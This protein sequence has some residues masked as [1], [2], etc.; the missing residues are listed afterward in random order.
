MGWDIRILP[1]FPSRAIV[2]TAS[3]TF[4][5]RAVLL[6]NDA[7]DTRR[8]KPQHD[9]KTNTHS[10]INTHTHTLSVSWCSANVS[11]RSEIR[12]TKLSLSLPAMFKDLRFKGCRWRVRTT[13]AGLRFFLSVLVFPP[14]V[15]FMCH[16]VSLWFAPVHLNHTERVEI[17]FLHQTSESRPG[18]ELNGCRPRPLDLQACNYGRLESWSEQ[19]Q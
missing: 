11:P 1:V 19:I 5:G 10:Y 6:P 3:L 14:R 2:P 17:I 4:G 16:Y 9:L 13:C 18:S 8:K 12:L 7:G 15:W